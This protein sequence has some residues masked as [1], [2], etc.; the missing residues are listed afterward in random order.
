MFCSDTTRRDVSLAW[1]NMHMSRKLSRVT[2]EI[3]SDVRAWLDS[4]AKGF[5]LA[6]KA[7][8]LTKSQARP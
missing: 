6:C 5:G 2:L 3:H 8:G 7:Q 1:L 4:K